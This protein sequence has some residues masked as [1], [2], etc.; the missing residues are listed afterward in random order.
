MANLVF[1]G[2]GGCPERGGWRGGQVS[3]VWAEMVPATMT[4]TG[5]PRMA[6][7]DQMRRLKS[8][9]EMG[10]CKGSTIPHT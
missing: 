6:L 8:N 3:G 9:T 10:H 2:P 1:G 7:P 5:S 4:G